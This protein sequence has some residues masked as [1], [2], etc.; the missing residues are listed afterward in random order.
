[1]NQGKLPFVVADQLIEIGPVTHKAQGVVGSHPAAAGVC[2][3]PE[4]VAVL[5][6]GNMVLI[7]DK[8]IHF[9]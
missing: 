1:M 7:I 2:R 4:A 8:R 9:L 6:L 3:G 5:F